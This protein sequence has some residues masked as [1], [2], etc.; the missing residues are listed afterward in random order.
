MRIRKPKPPRLD[1]LLIGVGAFS[2]LHGLYGLAGHNVT[3]L[4]AG[5]A[6]MAFGI[7]L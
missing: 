1:A 5:L 6:I 3:A 7:F 2:A 4:V